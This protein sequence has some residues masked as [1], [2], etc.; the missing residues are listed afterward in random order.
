[1]QPEKY[2]RNASSNRSNDFGVRTVDPAATGSRMIARHADISQWMN[3]DEAIGGER[4]VMPMCGR[5]EGMR[6][7][8]AGASS[9]LN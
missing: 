6:L 3:A 5:V 9:R 7:S 1:M 8:L 2:G 4:P